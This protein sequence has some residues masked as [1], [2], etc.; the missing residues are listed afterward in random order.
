[1]AIH[2]LSAA[3]IARLNTK[4]MYGDGGGLWL[5]VT[6]DGAGKSWLFRWTDRETGK[7]RVM[8]LGPVYK[9]D[10]AEARELAKAQWKLIEEGQDPV[11]TRAATQ[12]DHVHKRRLA[13]TV[14]QVVDEYL[15]AKMVGRSK[16]TQAGAHR[17]MNIIRQ[18]V[19]E[20]P[21][22]SIDTKIVL[23]TI[24]LREAWYKNN[25]K[26]VSLLTRLNGLFSYAIAN[27]Y[28]T[29]AHPTRW[30][31]H[32]EHILQASGDVHK[33]THHPSLPYQEMGRFMAA[34]RS[35]TDQ[36]IRK[37]GR[38]VLSLLIDFLCLNGAPRVSEARLAT[39][40]QI[41]RLNLIWSVPM[42]GHKTGK[43]TGQPLLRPITGPMLSVLD[44]MERRYPNHAPNDLIFPSW[45]KG[46][47]GGTRAYN[48]TSVNDF[49]T[50]TL[51]WPGHITIHGFRNTFTDWCRANAYPDELYD[52]QL[53]HVVGGKVQRAYRRDPLLNERRPMMDAWGDYCA[54]LSPK[55]VDGT[56]I[57]SL[58]E[59]KRKAS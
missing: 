24:G 54:R 45:H 27:G 40:D 36:S 57:E 33:V 37:T 3:K 41:D 49:L 4:G 42:D 15:T 1:M 43:I 31:D 9:V 29:K 55:P 59:H 51:K 25:P 30:K 20:L 18:A 12:V 22:K 47:N 2:K 58:A 8:G 10:L 32:L 26:A 46:L 48:L 7:G 11:A 21:I 44:E 35:N 39:W 13:K 17:Y 19:G 23:D 56:N 34:L 5:Q 14:N 16:W 50:V 28:Y 38:P 53:G 52:L 6:N